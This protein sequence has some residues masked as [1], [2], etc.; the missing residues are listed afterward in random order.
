MKIAYI[1]VSSVDQ[2]VDR[3]EIEADRHYKD[4][5]TGTNTDRPQLQ[6]MLSNLREGDEVHVWSIDR[7]ARSIKDLHDIIEVI[8]KAGASIT[9]IKESMTF[10]AD[11]TN[12]MNQLMLNLLG[13]VYEFETAIRKERQL[14]GIA[15]AKK[16]GVY[17]G[18]STDVRL[19]S[20]I[21]EALNNGTSQRN[22][23]KELDTSLSNVQRVIKKHKAV[24]SD[25]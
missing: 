8:T 2:N 12:P 13:S 23:A 18:R 1:R 21:I 15:K 25:S 20:A 14:E 19:K 3:Q 11:K 5:A 17:K 6:D 9:F 22:I 7:L 16:K 10:T 4:K 24:M